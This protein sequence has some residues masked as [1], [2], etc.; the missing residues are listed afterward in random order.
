MDNRGKVFL[1]EIYKEAEQK[2][3]MII[4]QLDEQASDLEVILE[5]IY[6]FRWKTYILYIVKIQMNLPGMWLSLI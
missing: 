6:R 2:Y 1:E 4:H 3:K 5:I